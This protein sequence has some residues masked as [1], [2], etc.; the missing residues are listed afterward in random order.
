METVSITTL[1]RRTTVILVRQ[2]TVFARQTTVILLAITHRGTTPSPSITPSPKRHRRALVITLLGLLLTAGAAA[3]GL[4]LF[5]NGSSQPARFLYYAEVSANGEYLAQ[6][7]INS[8]SPA[9]RIHV[10]NL[11]RRRIATTINE[12]GNDGNS[13]DDFELS[14]DGKT[15]AVTNTL[16]VGTELW[17][18]VTGRVVGTLTN[19]DGSQASCLAFSPDSRT[20]AV[21]DNSSGEDYN[22]MFLWDVPR[23][24]LL[25]TL[26]L[27][28]APFQAM[29]APGGKTLAIAVYPNG[30]GMSP[31]LKPGLEF[32]NI[33]S[34]KM[35]GSIP[36]NWQPGGSF[37]YSHDGR[38][39]DTSDS[40]GTITRWELT[41]NPIREITLADQDQDQ[42]ASD[43]P[44]PPSIEGM[45]VFSPDGMTLA[46]A[47]GNQTML[48]NLTP[49][50]TGRKIALLTDPN[51]TGVAEIAY[52]PDGKTLLTS[53]FNGKVYMWNVA[54][55]HILATLTNPA[56]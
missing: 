42:A 25:R 32:W 37:S 12:R 22:K 26:D 49:G 16:S 30:T 27:T 48:W 18:T 40:Y 45:T 10:W 51:S 7:T 56:T 1:V 50:A 3:G 54:T 34:Q 28:E 24:S 53:D 46:I 21:C 20:L 14:P 8:S 43:Y 29:F 44:P 13:I 38:T 31:S 17:N 47:D 52:T 36:I 33:G 55:R 4:L 5:T 11:A 35:N 19:P 41:G 15:I 6:A 23:R 2:A 39:L 9:Q